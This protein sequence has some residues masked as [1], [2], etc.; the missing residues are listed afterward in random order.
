MFLAAEVEPA[1]ANELNVKFQVP[2][3]QRGV[4]TLK[5]DQMASVN[6]QLQCYVISQRSHRS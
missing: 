2:Q 3:V 6:D 5:S 4:N 1:G